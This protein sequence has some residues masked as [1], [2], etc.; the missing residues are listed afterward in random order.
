MYDAH[1]ELWRLTAHFLN[2]LGVEDDCKYPESSHSPVVTLRLQVPSLAIDTYT[3]L[4]RGGSSGAWRLPRL[5][6]DVKYSQCDLH[7]L[8][9]RSRS[10]VIR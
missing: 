1:D 10:R 3:G 9:S 7:P 8:D 6:T 4:L 5:M 2:L